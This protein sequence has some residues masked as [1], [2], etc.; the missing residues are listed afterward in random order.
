MLFHIVV[1]VRDGAF[2]LLRGCYALGRGAQASHCIN[3]S[4]TVTMSSLRSF[5]LG[6]RSLLFFLMLRR[7]RCFV[8]TTVRF[9]TEQISGSSFRKK[10]KQK[11]TKVRSQTVLLSGQKKDDS[12][13]GSWFPRSHFR[14]HRRLQESIYP[15]IIHRGVLLTERPGSFMAI[16]LAGERAV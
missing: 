1:R 14:Q 4:P 7:P 2:S 9:L 11:N 16:I 15:L 5:L 10:V 6:L 3:S 13:L 8:T 12:E